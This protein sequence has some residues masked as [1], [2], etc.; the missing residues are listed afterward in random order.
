MCFLYKRQSK[1]EIKEK[2]CYPG[3][4]FT[5]DL[6]GV[7][8]SV[9]FSLALDSCDFDSGSLCDW[10]NHPD[11]PEL[12]NGQRY[13]WML[14]SGDTPSQNTGPAGDQTANGQ[15]KVCSHLF[16]CSLQFIVIRH[17]RN[18]LHVYKELSVS[19]SCSGITYAIIVKRKTPC[20]TDVFLGGGNNGESCVRGKTTAAHHKE[21]FR[22]KES[23][24]TR[25]L[26]VSLSP[27][28]LSKLVQHGNS[29][30]IGTGLSFSFLT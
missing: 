21:A 26:L 11:N 18:H 20:T 16:S 10:T 28:Q 19:S 8:P 4:L 23:C 9:V 14:R 15:G 7:L 5:L 27:I 22:A 1:T 3:L 24:Q 12:P 29:K 2:Q 13:D 30:G 17:H 25:V 6:K